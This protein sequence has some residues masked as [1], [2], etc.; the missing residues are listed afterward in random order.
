HRQPAA[1]VSAENTKQLLRRRSASDVCPTFDSKRPF[2]FY[3]A[4]DD[5][6]YWTFLLDASNTVRDITEGLKSKVPSGQNIYLYK[7]T[8]G[9]FGRTKDRRLSNEDRIWDIVDKRRDNNKSDPTFVVKKKKA[10][11]SSSNKKGQVDDAPS[12][13]SYSGELLNTSTS[14]NT[15]SSLVSSASG[16]AS[17]STTT[18]TTTT[19]ST[20]A[21]SPT[22]HTSGINNNN[23]NSS[24]TPPVATPPML[25]FLNTSPVQ[26]R[27]GLRTTMEMKPPPTTTTS[28]NDQSNESTSTSTSQ[29]QHQQQHQTHIYIQPSKHSS[30]NLK[31]PST[32]GRTGQTTKAIKEQQASFASPPS[33][34]V[35]ASQHTSGSGSSHSPSKPPKPLVPLVNISATGPVTGSTGNSNNNAINSTGSS[36]GGPSLNSSLGGSGGMPRPASPNPIAKRLE[37]TNRRSGKLSQDNSKDVMRL[38]RFYFGDFNVFGGLTNN[39]GGGRFFTLALLKETTA[40]DVG[41]SVEQKLQLP[42]NSINV[43]LVLPIQ[44]NGS[45][46]ERMLGD[47]ELIIDVKDTWEDPAQTFFIVK[48]NDQKSRNKKLPKQLADVQQH[49]VIP[50]E[51]RRSTDAISLR[52]TAEDSWK[53]RSIP[54]FLQ[55]LPGSP[56]AKSNGVGPS[57]LSSEFNDYSGPDHSA[58]KYDDSDDEDASELDVTELMGWAHLIPS[59]DLEYI[60]RIGSGTYSKVYKG[61][62]I[63]KFVAIKTLRG[64][65]TPEQIQGFRKECDVLST[66]KSPHLISFYGS[67]IEDSQ[68][69]MVVEYCSRGTLYK[70]LNTSFDFEWDK[71]FRWMIQVVEGVQYLHNMNPPMVHRDLK[72]LNILL[73]AEYNTKLCDFG[74]TRTM[75]MT[76]V[77]TL[78][79]LRGT[80]AYT[81]PEIYDGMLFNTKSDVYSLGVIMWE[82]VQRCITGAYQRPFHDY[83][84]SMDIQIIILTSKNKVRPKL[85]EGC[86]ERLKNLI[87]NCWD[88]DPNTRPTTSDLL[89]ELNAIKKQVMKIV[90]KS[91]R[92]CVQKTAKTV[93][94]QQQTIAAAASAATVETPA[95]ATP[96]PEVIPPPAAIVESTTTSTTNDNDNNNNNGTISVDNSHNHCNNSNNNSTTIDTNTINQQQQCS[97]DVNH[98]DQQQDITVAVQQNDS[99]H[100]TNISNSNNNNNNSDSDINTELAVAPTPTPTSTSAI[101]SE[102]SDTIGMEA[103]I[104]D[105]SSSPTTSTP[106]TPTIPTT[107]TMS[108]ESSAMSPLDVPVA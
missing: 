29:P 44:S 4:N 7:R 82:L 26:Q 8:K 16:S 85:H 51:W 73:S 54:I 22:T 61:R 98:I 104:T 6:M 55:V 87:T 60:K 33:S 75:T 86:P 78:G 2:R 39:D 45:K 108:T 76:N 48:E 63:D 9:K 71:W 95:T 69:S 34:P 17:T 11:S 30:L 15:S 62:Y 46:I 5:H 93:Q 65:M 27:N 72:T 92:S 19:T 59:Q 81:A 68:L 25:P 3:W 1:A 32:A 18:T 12:P 49:N 20:S 94:L 13:L 50:S 42:P 102:V 89:S 90:E 10:S 28:E 64:N 77:S 101:T 56:H 80:M 97:I 24:T 96:T 105:H 35:V 88:Q 99:D 100:C 40:R 103:A 74:L 91:G 14:S 67:C 23:N 47:E 38:M 70:V 83:P 107:T 36:A 53:R 106:T 52:N 58:D 21:V 79:M 57:P 31:S 84:I 37:G 43:V 66:I 41:I